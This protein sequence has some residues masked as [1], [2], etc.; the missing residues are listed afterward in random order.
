ML[1]N[2]WVGVQALFNEQQKTSLTA[3]AARVRALISWNAYCEPLTRAPSWN[4]E[5]A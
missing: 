5:S 2:K 3:A 4:D 1:V